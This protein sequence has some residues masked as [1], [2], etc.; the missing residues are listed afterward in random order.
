MP[1]LVQ[2]ALFIVLCLASGRIA[3]DAAGQAAG[4]TPTP[5]AP[6]MLTTDRSFEIL[7]QGRA[8]LIDFRFHEAEASFTRLANR[9]DGRAAGMYH[10]SFV[11]FLRYLMSDREVDAEGFVL[12]SDELRR[13]LEGE[14][15]T[16]WRHLL[17]AETNLQRTVVWAKQGR[18]VRA[19]LAGRN[20][21][22]TYSNLV[23]TYP[24]FHEA[25]KGYGVLQTAIS[26]LPSTYKRFLALVGFTG[27]ADVGSRSL[28]L[29]AVEGGYMREEA[30]AYLALFDVL[31]DGSKG[32]G[33]A[34]LR[35]LHARHP[36]SPLFAHL[37]GY[38]LFENRNA[39]EAEQVFRGAAA[40]YGEASVFYIDYVDHFLGMTLF[41]QN[42]FEEATRYLTRYRANHDGDALM[43]PTMLYLGLS[44]EMLDR[45]AEALAAYRQ[46]QSSRELDTDVVSMRMAARLIDQAMT[47]IQRRLL[48][49]ANAYDAG[50]YEE[51]LELLIAVRNE[52]GA[53]RP[54]RSE[55][56]YRL[57]R[58]YQATDRSDEALESYAEAVQ[59]HGGGLERWAPWSDYHIGEIHAERGHTADARAAFER[60]LSYPGEYDY[61]QALESSARH[62]LHQLDRES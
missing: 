8:A 54:V 46:V 4:S 27:N 42:R 17:G 58:L 21:Y 38:Y 44:L 51:A 34:K 6:M 19:A 53:S 5:R 60:A 18:Y 62:A 9:P 26:S 39:A 49:G 56:A 15:D 13:T 23:S 32:D 36:E 30:S 52:Q 37:L 59:L 41:R 35:G 50:N 7:E 61:Y 57:G 31:L 14:P 3:A 25:Y 1:G 16:P 22:R 28:H 24:E 11:S 43:A 10:L 40:C 48:R 12:R 33:E 47:P 29:A 55:A 45:R 20:A 2:R